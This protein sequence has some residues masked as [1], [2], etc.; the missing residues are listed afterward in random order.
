MKMREDENIAKYVEQIKASVSAI[1]ASEA[2]ID[3][4]IVVRKVLRTLLPIYAIRVSFIQE[5]RCDPNSNITLDALV[6]RLTSFE[7]D[8]YDNYVPSSKGIEYVFEAKLSLKKKG[9]KSKANQSESEEEEESSDNDL[10]VVEALLVRKYSKG[11]GKYKGKIP[12]I[13]F[14]CEEVGHIVARCPK[15]EDKDE[16]KSNKFKGKKEFKNYK[17]YKDKGKKSYFTAKDSDNNEDEMVYI[18]V[19][20]ESDDE[21]DKMVII[22]HVRTNDTW[23]IDSGYSHHMTGDNKKI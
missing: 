21:G 14:S 4:K 22:S 19:K 7:L 3:D 11:R 12:L 9:K 6:G 20:D 15:K 5:M 10:E 16:K 1:K 18:V 2:D 17:D 23:I 8:N 13:Y